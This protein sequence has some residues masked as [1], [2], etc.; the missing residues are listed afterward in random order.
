MKTQTVGL[1]AVS[2]TMHSN[3]ITVQL[4]AYIATCTFNEGA[5]ALLQILHAMQ[6]LLGPNAHAYAVVE[7][8]HRV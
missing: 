5:R 3:N 6:V 4:A 2:K 8:E 7:D 1:L